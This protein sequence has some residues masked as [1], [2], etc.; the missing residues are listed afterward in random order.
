[1]LFFEEDKDK[2]TANADMW[3]LLVL[4]SASSSPRS[5][6]VER[7]DGFRS[8]V[9]AALFFFFFVRFRITEIKALESGD[10]GG[11]LV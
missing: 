5:C 6:S 3:H 4:A 8:G 2:R 7:Q 9:S 1:M 11:R 10:E